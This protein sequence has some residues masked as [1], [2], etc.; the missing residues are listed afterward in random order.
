MSIA[1]AQERMYDVTISC[2]NFRFGK[3]RVRTKNKYCILS[4]GKERFQTKTESTNCP[5]VLDGPVCSCV[6]SPLI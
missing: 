5:Q 6:I 4:F 1:H 2:I 3:E